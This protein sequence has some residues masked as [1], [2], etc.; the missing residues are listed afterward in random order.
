M[1]DGMQDGSVAVD[2]DIDDVDDVDDDVTSSRRHV[3][4]HHVK[5]SEF[6]ALRNLLI[7]HRQTRIDLSMLVSQLS[8][9]L[10]TRRPHTAWMDNVKTWTGLPVEESIRMTEDRDKW[11]KY[12]HGVANPGIEDG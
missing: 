2:I 1:Y 12:V 3:V 11:R 5:L 4:Q 6:T 7:F 10:S 8:F 9:G